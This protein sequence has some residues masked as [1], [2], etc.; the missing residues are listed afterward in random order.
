VLRT[1]RYPGCGWLTANP[2]V[3]PK[4]RH[5]RIGDGTPGTRNSGPLCLDERIGLMAAIDE[6]FGSCNLLFP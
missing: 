3:A 2:E 6:A 4:R 5:C 1:S